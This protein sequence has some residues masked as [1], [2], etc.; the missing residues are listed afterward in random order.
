MMRTDRRDVDDAGMPHYCAVMQH[1]AGLSW[2][3]S[4]AAGDL[5]GPAGGSTQQA[6]HASARSPRHRLQFATEMLHSTQLSGG[7]ARRQPG[8]RDRRCRSAEPGGAGARGCG[9]GAARRPQQQPDAAPR[10]VGGPRRRAQRSAALDPQESRSVAPAPDGGPLHAQDERRRAGRG[11]DL[12]Y[13]PWRHRQRAGARRGS[14]RAARARQRH[15]GDVDGRLRPNASGAAGPGGRGRRRSRRR[16]KTAAATSGDRGDRRRGDRLVVA[17]Q[18]RERVDDRDERRENSSAPMKIRIAH[19]RRDLRCT[20]ALQAGAD[21]RHRRP[22][23]ERRH[24][25]Q[26]SAAEGL[27]ARLR[28]RAPG[29]ARARRWRR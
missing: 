12:Q 14:G 4:A 6:G 13:P 24:R 5:A 15:D 23:V 20:R 25:A 28:M 21:G 19:D 1:A 11:G 26:D 27:Q 17:A 9:R 10:P 22:V 16:A 18:P 7:A 29:A 8:A 3:S 2:S